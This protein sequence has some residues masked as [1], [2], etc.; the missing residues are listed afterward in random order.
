ME[1]GGR[2]G[3]TARHREA[4]RWVSP[5]TPSPSPSL[6]CWI[7]FYSCLRRCS[8]YCLDLWYPRLLLHFPFEFFIKW[9]LI[10]FL[11]VGGRVFT[12]GRGTT[13]QLGHGEMLNSLHPKPVSSLQSY[14]ITQVS[15]GWSHSGFVSGS[16]SFMII[17]VS[18]IFE[19]LEKN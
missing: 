19:V 14:V 7:Y 18:S 4:W 13:G 5:S 15:A 11:F 17:I 12:W 9:Q 8:C 2:N 10:K 3:G 1:L 6:L 16:F